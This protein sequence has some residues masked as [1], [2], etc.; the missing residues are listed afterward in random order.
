MWK[1][2]LVVAPHLPDL[3]GKEGQLPENIV[4]QTTHTFLGMVSKLH[5]WSL[6]QICTCQKRCQSIINSALLALGSARW[7]PHSPHPIHT[8]PVLYCTPAATIQDP[9]HLFPTSF[10]SCLPA[11]SPSALTH[12]FPPLWYCISMIFYDTRVLISRLRSIYR[13]LNAWI[14]NLNRKIKLHDK[15][16]NKHWKKKNTGLQ[17]GMRWRQ[18]RFQLSAFGYRYFKFVILWLMLFLLHCEIMFLMKNLT[19]FCFLRVDWSDYPLC[20]M[21]SLNFWQIFWWKRRT[22]RWKSK[23][24]KTVCCM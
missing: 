8:S 9:S 3:W 4:M 17:K 6:L 2:P 22:S 1:K 23:V 10:L 24:L 13:M 12:D 11:H 16:L 20:W 21:K 18:S 14:K 15:S 5:S 7:E 19:F